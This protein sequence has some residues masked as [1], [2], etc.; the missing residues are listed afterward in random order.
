MLGVALTQMQDPALD[1]VEP[2]KV[3]TGPFLK[4]VQVPLDGIPFG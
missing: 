3:H 2:H 1:L 4:L